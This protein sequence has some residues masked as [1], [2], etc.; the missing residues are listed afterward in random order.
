MMKKMILTAAVILAAVL[1]FCS[2]ELLAGCSGG[3]ENG[4]EKASASQ[5]HGP[6]ER[7]YIAFSCNTWG[8]IEPVKA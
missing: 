8:R 7:I 2:S 5:V 6:Q 4:A 1:T 3:E